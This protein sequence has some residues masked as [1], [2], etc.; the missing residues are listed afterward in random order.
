MLV[1]TLAIMELTFRVMFVQLPTT[2]TGTI[3][4]PSTTAI[5]LQALPVIAQEIIRVMHTIMEQD[6]PSIQVHV[7]DSIIIII[8]VIKHM[9]Q[10]VA[11][12]GKT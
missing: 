7:V 4:L 1:V 9:Y 11:V 10:N 12:Y 6:I 3:S 8:E 2:P 5:L